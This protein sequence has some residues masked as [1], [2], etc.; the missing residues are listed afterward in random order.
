MEDLCQSSQ[1]T[2]SVTDKST[3]WAE[4]KSGELVALNKNINIISLYSSSSL[5]YQKHKI[6]LI[7]FKML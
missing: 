1:E 2:V 3:N 6:I 7:V 5:D 4:E